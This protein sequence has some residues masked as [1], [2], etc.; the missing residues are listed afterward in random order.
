MACPKGYF[1]WYVR[2]GL[3]DSEILRAIEM[4]IVEIPCSSTSR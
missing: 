4:P 2:G 3:T 1:K